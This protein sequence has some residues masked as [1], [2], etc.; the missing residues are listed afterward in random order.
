MPPGISS[1]AGDLLSSIIGGIFGMIQQ[2]RQ[3]SYNLGMLREQQNFARER[4]DL[5]WARQMDASN[6]AYQ[7]QIA[8]LQAAG[9]NPMLAVSSAGGASQPSASTSGSP[10][11]LPLDTGKLLDSVLAFK[12]FSLQRAL[13]NAQ[14]EKLDADK[15]NVEA[16]TNLKNVEASHTTERERGA[17]IIN[18]I[19]EATK[20]AQVRAAE[21]E[22]V[23]RETNNQV[24]WKRMDEINA[25]ITKS[26]EET[27]TEQAK[28]ALYEIEGALKHASA[29][30]IYALVPY[31]QQLMAAQTEEAKAAA[32]LSSVH[33]AYQQGLIDAG[34]IDSL[35]REA[36]ANAGVAED[37]QMLEDIK[38]GLR[39]GKWPESLAGSIGKMYTAE[40]FMQGMTVLLDNL[41]PLAGLLK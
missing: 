8:D 35:A 1:G 2:D 24:L 18:D 14:I 40:G 34:Y 5:A 20:D 25:N 23:L 26:I 21:L 6:T 37:K 27:H 4:E 16:D 36:A 39:T 12:N 15:K 11:A 32:V 10:S 22:N 29:Y 13:I 7:R 19:N 31:Q 41:N 28:Q 38:T 9:L 17:R 3:H 33:T 30:Q